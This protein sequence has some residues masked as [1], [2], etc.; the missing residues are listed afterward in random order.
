MKSLIYRCSAAF[1]AMV[2][3]VSCEIFPGQSDY[4]T[5][6]DLESYTMD[7]FCGHVIMPML[8]TEFAIE[9]DSYLALPDEDRINDY[10]FY[11]NIFRTDDGSYVIDDGKTY[12]SVRTGGKSI[13]NPGASWEF[14]SFSTTTYLLSH[15]K[16]YCNMSDPVILESFS[17]SASGSSS[18]LFT[19]SYGEDCVGLDIEIQDDRYVWNIS[20]SGKIEDTDGYWAEFMTDVNGI[21]VMS[22]HNDYLDDDEFICSGTFMVNIFHNDEPLDWCRVNFSSGYRPSFKTSL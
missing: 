8:M 13:R 14:L 18:M 21:D 10:R 3:L 9:L 2:M 16:I 12:C 15:G 6:D 4:L 20:T 22:R 1:A 17:S 19:M 7:V 5:S 11:G